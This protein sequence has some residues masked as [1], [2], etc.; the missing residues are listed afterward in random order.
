MQ[1][2]KIKFE[3]STG[4]ISKK[5][6]VFYNP[7]KKIDRDLNVEILKILKPKTGLDLLAASGIRGL[8]LATECSMEM[9]L[10]DLN[11]K[12]VKLIRKNAKLNNLSVKI[13]NQEANHFLNSYKG[14]FDYVDVDPFGPPIQ[15][16]DGAIIKSKKWIGVTATDSSALCGSYPKA[17]LR[18]Y[19]SKPL[20]T[21]YCH[22]LGIRILI[23]YCIKT[24]A[25]YDIGLIPIFSYSRKDYFRVY[26]KIVKGAKKCDELLKKIGYWQDKELN[27]SVYELGEKSYENVCGPLWLGELWDEKLVNKLPKTPFLNLIKNES[28]IKTIGFYHLP[29]IFSKTK[30]NMKRELLIEKL[31]KKGFKASRTHFDLQGIRTNAKFEE[32][33]PLL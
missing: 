3:A 17:C 14:K 12:A 19:G 13:F 26:F 31:Q 9:T 15:F 18:K 8:R 5:L 23:S 28:V 22:E 4:K 33:I 29:Q 10:N 11:V 32:I 16:L 6:D 30:K 21:K 27:M 20:K 24:G 7:D 2:G 1:E 25:K